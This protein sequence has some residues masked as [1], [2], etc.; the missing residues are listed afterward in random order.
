L[1]DSDKLIFC[2]LI[3]RFDDD[4]VQQFAYSLQISQCDALGAS[5]SIDFFAKDFTSKKVTGLAQP[6]NY[7]GSAKE[8]ADTILLFVVDSPD[9][10]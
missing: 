5:Y 3:A 1:D 7:D 2:P 8:G 9:S 4:L 10:L 6:R